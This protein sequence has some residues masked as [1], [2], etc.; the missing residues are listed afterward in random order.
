MNLKEV[1]STD[2]ILL[3]GDTY[4]SLKETTFSIFLLKEMLNSPLD[5]MTAFICEG[6]MRGIAFKT[7]FW[8]LV[9]DIARQDSE[10]ESSAQTVFQQAACNNRSTQTV[11][12]AEFNQA[13]MTLLSELLVSGNSCECAGGSRPYVLAYS[14]ERQ[15][16]I[17]LLFKTNVEPFFNLSNARI[18]ELGC[19]NGMATEALR[20]LGYDIYAFDSD[21]CA[22]CEGLLH[23][24][25]EKGKTLVLD[26]RSLSQYDFA[27]YYHFDCIL[28]FML[29]AI[30]E[31][32]NAEWEKILREAVS[33]LTDGLLVFTV[34]KREE[35]DF[36]QSVMDSLRVRGKL[37]DNR[38]DTSI[39]DQWVYIGV[40][41]EASR[42]LQ[43]DSTFNA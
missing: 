39:Y 34:H 43:R 24:A 4:G 23:G 42:H 31:F 37:V 2:S 18:L 19:G 1:L 13:V 21:K 6:R 5:S 14:P 8:T 26:G 22:V 36:V 40:K 15:E 32:N 10:F 25:L 41:G 28:G 12:T 20:E 17:Q 3:V 7:D 29:G 35:A 16:R 33:V 38:S 27:K 9:T 30:Y 11:E